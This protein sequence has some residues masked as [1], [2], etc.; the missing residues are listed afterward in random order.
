MQV[1]LMKTGDTTRIE[2]DGQDIT[3]GLV[4]WSVTKTPGE[5]QG[6]VVLRGLLWSYE[7]DADVTVKAEHNLPKDGDADESL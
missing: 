1:A 5:Q 3:A 2:L 6:H 4:S 7:G